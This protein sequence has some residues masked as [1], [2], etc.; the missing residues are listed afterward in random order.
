LNKLWL[1]ECSYV[2]EKEKIEL[3]VYVNRT[4]VAELSVGV[5]KLEDIIILHL[6]GGR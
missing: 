4:T 6:V 3:E 5:K 1:I 2:D